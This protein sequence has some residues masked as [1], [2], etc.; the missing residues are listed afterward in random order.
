MLLTCIPSAL[1]P[2][3]LAAEGA[4]STFDISS[5]VTDAVTTTQGQLFTVLGIVVP[6]IVAV[7]AAVVGVKFGIKWLRSIKG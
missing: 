7:V 1:M 2:M 5:V 4:A 3:A 6:A